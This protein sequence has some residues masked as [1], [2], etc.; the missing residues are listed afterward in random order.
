MKK[1]ANKEELHRTATAAQI[2]IADDKLDAML[3][4]INLV[5]DFCAAVGEFKN[6]EKVEFSWTNRADTKLR[7]DIPVEWVDRDH[8]ME[9]APL[10]EGDFF[11]APQLMS[12]V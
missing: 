3:S 2:S 6:E 9:N 12:E 10:R 7:E 8:F 4:E 5:L 1:I 11:K